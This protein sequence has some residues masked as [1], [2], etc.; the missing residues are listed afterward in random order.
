MRAGT[1]PL[2][3]LM[4]YPGTRRPLF[5]SVGGVAIMQT[6]PP[7]EAHA[8]LMDN[9]AQEVARRG[10]V[11]LDALRKM[12]ERSDALGFG[13]NMGDV[14]PSLHAFAVPVQAAGGAFAAVCIVGEAE[15]YGA[16]RL[17]EIRAE[18]EAAAEA[19]RADAQELVFGNA[20]AEPRFNM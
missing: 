11:R 9:V 10:P 3:A 2:N 12:R 1:V 4:V 15:R 16:E 7:E 19:L 17:A 13:A 8:V 5:T 6:L 20:G 18:L 14:V